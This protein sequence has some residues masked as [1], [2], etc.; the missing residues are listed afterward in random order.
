MELVAIMLLGAI[1][2]G[3][4]AQ[5]RGR[6]TPGWALL[7]AFFPLISLLILVLLPNLK[8]QADTE[9]LARDVDYQRR[10]AEQRAV[11]ERVPEG[12]VCPRCAETVKAAAQV[13]RFC[14]H[15]FPPA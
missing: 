12:K 15:E 2:N 10:L 1:L 9:A 11:Q 4:L 7:G 3:M 14:G 6:N 5:S 13:C 8:E